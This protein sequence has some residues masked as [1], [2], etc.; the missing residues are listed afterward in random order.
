MFLSLNQGL[1]YFCTLQHFFFV[2]GTI[3]KSSFARVKV[4]SNH[5]NLSRASL[6]T[7]H[8]NPPK[9][10]IYPLRRAHCHP[11]P[12]PVWYDEKR[13]YHHTNIHSLI[14]SISPFEYA[15]AGMEKGVIEF[16]PLA[17]SSQ[18]SWPTFLTSFTQKKVR[19]YVLVSCIIL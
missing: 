12:C 5:S 19:V 2:F 6:T 18:S 9:K 4:L 8:Y 1:V 14:Q 15:P 11:G 17:A 16:R 13:C 3:I 10:S 7:L